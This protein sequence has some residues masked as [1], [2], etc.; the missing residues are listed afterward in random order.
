MKKIAATIL[1]SFLL[2]STNNPVFSAT[3]NETDSELCDA[4]KYSLILSFSEQINKAIGEIYKN[5]SDVPKPLTW[6][7][8]ST[9]I[10]K[11]KQLNGIGGGYELTL[12]VYP[13]YR[14]HITYGEDKIVVN[15]GGELIN[16]K[17]L[18]T[19]PVVDFN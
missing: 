16:F 14:A 8:Y 19:Y 15:T 6:D 11:I 12:K 4:L 17:H 9:Q 5:D 7:A 2:I 3:I 13:Y 10:L 18:K 1:F